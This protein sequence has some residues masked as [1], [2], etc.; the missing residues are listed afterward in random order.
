MKNSKRTRRLPSC[1]FQK[2]I[3]LDFE[4]WIN[5]GNFMGALLIYYLLVPFFSPLKF[6]LFHLKRFVDHSARL[7]G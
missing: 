3:I 6:G 2:V 7:P 4:T 1:I 5:V